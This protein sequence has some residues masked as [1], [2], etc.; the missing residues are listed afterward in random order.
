MSHHILAYTSSLELNSRISDLPVS[1]IVWFSSNRRL[2][3]ASR[4]AC[5][6]EV[7]AK[8]SSDC[9][10]RL[11]M[12]SSFNVVS[13]LFKLAEHSSQAAGHSVHLHSCCSQEHVDSHAVGIDLCSEIGQAL[14][15][16]LPPDLRGYI[17]HEVA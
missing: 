9:L 17:F 8:A 1:I 5:V 11:F 4:D 15:R 14:R 12:C 3:S 6:A 2:I 7:S 16:D 13:L 10:R